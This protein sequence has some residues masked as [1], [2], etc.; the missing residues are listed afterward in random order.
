[1]VLKYSKLK[2]TVF[3]N[4]IQHTF[5]TAFLIGLCMII[6]GQEQ[7]KTKIWASDGMPLSSNDGLMQE[8][9]NIVYRGSTSIKIW[10]AKGDTRKF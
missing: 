6:Y 1:M 7:N 3:S 2:L 9:I 8:H 4:K 5:S 10:G